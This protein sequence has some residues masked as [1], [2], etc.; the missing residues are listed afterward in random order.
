[1]ITQPT[2]VELVP[3]L[4]TRTASLAVGNSTVR[5]QG[6][7][8]V[9]SAARSA[10]NRVDL[11][12]IRH[13]NNGEFRTILDEQT[14]FVRRKLP[15]GARHWGTARKCLN[16]FLRDVLYNHYLCQHFGF[17]RL[18]KFLE[19]PLD[20]DVARGLL[21]EPEGANLP[22]WRTIKSLDR[23]TSDQYQ[24]AAARIAKRWQ[25]H[26]VHLDVIFWRME[27]PRR[28]RNGD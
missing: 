27:K 1:M 23:T 21:S 2:K 16:I 20:S 9:V 25:T 11:I 17:S 3:L 13:A 14:E 7:P 26:A 6:A 4:V 24:A 15:S 5:N 28:V 8:G 18:E 19:I 10:L 12:K 22:K